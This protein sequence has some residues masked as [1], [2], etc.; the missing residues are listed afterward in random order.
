MSINPFNYSIKGTTNDSE[1]EVLRVISEF[2][3]HKNNVY[4]CVYID[5]KD[6]YL[7]VWMKTKISKLP[8]IT[9][10]K[11]IKYICYTV[12]VTWHHIYLK[13]STETSPK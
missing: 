4:S 9:F 1:I 3:Q 5:N 8:F 10:L 11:T 12:F 6:V 2:N 13:I 7:Y